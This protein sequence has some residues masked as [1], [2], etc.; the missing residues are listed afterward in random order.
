MP[1]VTLTIEK[2][3][4]TYLCPL[5]DDEYGN[6]RAIEYMR[7]KYIVCGEEFPSWCPLKILSEQKLNK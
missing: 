7:G 3:A 4:D 2:P 1:K 5:K 6:C